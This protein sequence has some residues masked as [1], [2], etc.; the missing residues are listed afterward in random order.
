M[1][2][3]LFI[4]GASGF[5]AMNFLK[6]INF[7]EYDNVYCLS[8]NEN[9]TLGSLSKYKNFKFIKG[10]LF[11]TDRYAHLLASVDAVL[12]F[13]AATGK[14]RP[15]DYFRT[16]VEGTELLIK[17]CEKASVKNFLFISS[18]SVKFDDISKYYYAQSKKTAEESVKK[19]TMN[20]TIVR[21]TIVIGSGSSILKSL[22]KLADKSIVPIF[23]DGKSKI[24]PVYVDDLSDCIL[25]IINENIFN[26][27]IYEI[28]GPEVITIEAFIKSIH[29][30]MF[31]KE[32]KTF[33]I[34]LNFVINILSVFEKFFYSYLPVNIGQLSS[35]RYD[36]TAEDNAVLL[37]RIPKMK[38]I[39]EMLTLALNNI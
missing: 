26:N 19:C 1:K 33:H 16:N 2:M 21:P 32:P 6:K 9:V 20:Y 34:P 4:T 36:G 12:H 23:G 38:S 24:Q 10:S 25:S 18:I 11:D 17:L 8:R 30:H 15:E 29:R 28:G 35:F 27:E 14:A 31:N 39:D 5:I 22:L 37:R 3:S 13:A 7:K